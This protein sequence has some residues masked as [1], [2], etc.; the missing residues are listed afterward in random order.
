[1]YIADRLH[2][3]HIYVCGVA[4]APLMVHDVL[5]HECDDRPISPGAVAAAMLTSN[6]PLGDTRPIEPGSWTF[7]PAASGSGHASP[8]PTAPV[9]L[10]WPLTPHSGA[11]AGARQARGGGSKMGG[12][13]M[14]HGYVDRRCCTAHQ[15]G[16]LVGPYMSGLVINDG[17][18]PLHGAI[19]YGYW[20]AEAPS[21]RSMLGRG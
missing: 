18:M 4:S 9:M 1:V 3:V 7:A 11:G 6:M 10:M 15:D 21:R 14:A 13:P 17:A 20:A 19:A 2:L 12:G 16:L 5:H 8:A